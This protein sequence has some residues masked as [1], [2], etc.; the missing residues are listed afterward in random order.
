MIT[1][2]L[3][4]CVAL[5]AVFFDGVSKGGFGGGLGVIAVP[6]MALAIAPAQ[7]AA[8]M[9]PLLVI[10]DIFNV[11]SYRGRWNRRE[12]VMI[13][14]FAAIGIAI[15]GLSFHALNENTIRIILGVISVVF[16]ANWTLRQLI[17]KPQPQQPFSVTKGGACSTVA[18][19]TSF[20]AHAGGP[21]LS[22]YLLP[23]HLEKTEYQATTALIFGVTNVFK[24]VPYALLGQLSVQ[25]ITTSMALLPVGLVGVVAG[26]YAHQR[27][28]QR[29]FYITIYSLLW[30][31]GIKLLYSGFLGL[32]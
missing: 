24:L 30:L 16:A 26:I 6:M 18:G 17:R 12:A 5:P 27:L 2:L 15:G 8:I 9:L 19:F 4:Y 32:M 3:F 20:I 1:D 22:L 31:L 28:S 13:I 14:G 11:W 7:A 21:P 10:M 29:W 23:R 25:N